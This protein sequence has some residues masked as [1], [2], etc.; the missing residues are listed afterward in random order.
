MGTQDTLHNLFITFFV[1]EMSRPLALFKMM[2]VFLFD[3]FKT[4]ITKYHSDYDII[5]Q[6]AREFKYL[7]CPPQLIT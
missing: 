2:A 3:K 1:N 6:Y 7:K 4:V 5:Q